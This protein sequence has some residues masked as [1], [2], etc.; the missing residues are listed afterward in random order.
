MITNTYFVLPMYYTLFL[1]SFYVHLSI[2]K[3]TYE[4]DVIVMLI[5]PDGETEAQIK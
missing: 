2:F 5:F 3:T 4:I 1:G